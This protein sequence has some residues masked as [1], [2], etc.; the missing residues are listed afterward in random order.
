MSTQ[1]GDNGWQDQGS[2][3]ASYTSYVIED[4]TRTGNSP[5]ISISRNPKDADCTDKHEVLSY[6]KILESGRY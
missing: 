1:A 5:T 3:E 6:I 4:L 2:D